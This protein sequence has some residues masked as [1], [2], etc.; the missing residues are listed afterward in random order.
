MPDRSSRDDT[1][2]AVLRIT[3]FDRFDS[4]RGPSGKDLTWKREDGQPILSRDDNRAY[5]QLRKEAHRRTN[6]DELDHGEVVVR[7]WL[8]DDR[9]VEDVEW[10]I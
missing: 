6:I 8:G 9:T 7:I 2:D 10:D 3:D 5:Q 4:Q 1:H